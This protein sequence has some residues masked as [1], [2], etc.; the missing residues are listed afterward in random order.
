MQG[1]PDVE[2]DVVSYASAVR[3]CERSG[4]CREALLL[5][6]DMKAASLAADRH[7]STR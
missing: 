6:E 7:T 5:F 2:V 1:D 3:A 4:R